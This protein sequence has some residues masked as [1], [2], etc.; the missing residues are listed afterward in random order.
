M[1]DE[2]RR[3]GVTD[4]QLLDIAAVM[5]S[6]GAAHQAL[7]EALR[8]RFHDLYVGASRFAAL[9]MPERPQHRIRRR[10]PKFGMSDVPH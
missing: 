4:E 7:I 6:M 2:L 10:R 9:F 1:S 8:P 3:L 5:G